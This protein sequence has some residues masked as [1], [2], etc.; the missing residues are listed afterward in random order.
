MYL[1]GRVGL[2]NKT[3]APGSSWA[4]RAWCCSGSIVRQPAS[5]LAWLPTSR[6]KERATHWHCLSNVSP[7]SSRW[8]ARAPF[9]LFRSS[10]D[11][12]RLETSRSPGFY[13]LIFPPSPLSFLRF[14]SYS[15]RR[16][17]AL[18]FT[19]PKYCIGRDRVTFHVVFSSGSSR[20]RGEEARNQHINFLLSRAISFLLL[21]CK[22][23]ALGNL[24]VILL[25]DA[26]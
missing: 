19:R 24:L 12:R 10:R 11:H 16:F 25:T 4:T 26:T 1:T 18:W 13:L 5:T 3:V 14:P 22:I 9:S 17:E 20:Q 21:P 15:W 6:D 7:T 23:F 2:C 8:R